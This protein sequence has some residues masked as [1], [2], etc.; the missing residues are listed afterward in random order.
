MEAVRPGVHVLRPRKWL[1]RYVGPAADRSLGRQVAAA[2]S[3]LGLIDP[4][5]W[6]NDAS[7]ARWALGTGWPT[8]YDVTDD[9]LLAPLAPRQ[10]ARLRADDELLLARSGAVVVCSPDLARTRGRHRTVDL[11]PNGVD[12]ELFTT[13]QPRPA[14]LPDAPVAVYVGTLHEERLDVDLVVALAAARPDVSVALVGPDSLGPDA[15]ARL[16]AV[17][18]VHR[19]GAQP[20]DRVPG[21]LQHADVVV[22]PHRVNPFTESL[23]PIKAYECVAAGRPTVATPVAGFRD[24]GPPV[25]VADRDGFVAAVAGVLDATRP[26]PSGTDPSPVVASWHERAEAMLAVMERVRTGA[27]AP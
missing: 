7:Y 19:L 2:A 18:T 26:E 5:V 27:V 22:V 1:P 21:F 8:L 15:S 25:V 9:W 24:L 6:V 3:S 10:E 13:P 12:V 16:A 17:P 4:L 14:E 23:D 11:I 20:Y